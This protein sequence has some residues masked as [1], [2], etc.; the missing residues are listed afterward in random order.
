ME[1]KIEERIIYREAEISDALQLSVLLGHVFI[2]TY[3]TE[4]VNSESA[5]FIFKEFSVKN[6]EKLIMDNSENI[7]IA[8]YK[9]NI[10][11]VAEMEFNKICPVDNIIAPELNKL[12]VLE[13]FCGKGIG[14]NLLK[15]VE[16]II[17]T[18]EVNEI[19]LSV[20]STNERAVSFY[21][22]QGFKWIGNFDF[23]MEFSSHDNKVMHKKL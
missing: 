13:R 10:V 1:I 19:W 3:G 16:E 17:I 4:G 11:G 18:K 9:D 23:Q 2:D 7:I 8:T 12:Y 20:L 22:R 6:T 14:Y 21:E 5:N 15:K